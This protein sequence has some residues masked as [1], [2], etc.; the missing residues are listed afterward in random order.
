M[1]SLFCKWILNS[2]EAS[3]FCIGIGM[4]DSRFW[5]RLGPDWCKVFSHAPGLLGGFLSPHVWGP[6][7]ACDQGPDQRVLLLAAAV[8]IV[9][10]RHTYVWP[11]HRSL[12]TSPESHPRQDAAERA[13]KQ[14]PA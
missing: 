6:I 8:T 5:G 1:A 9:A 10:C 3:L 12:G 11:D 13:C 7:G 4:S 14:Q 2:W